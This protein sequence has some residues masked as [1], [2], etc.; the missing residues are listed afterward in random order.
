MGEKVGAVLFRKSDRL[1]QRKSQ[2]VVT[3]QERDM[4]GRDG[5]K[6]TNESMD[7]VASR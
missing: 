7:S 3:M 4:D 1:S 2:K 6:L 5:G